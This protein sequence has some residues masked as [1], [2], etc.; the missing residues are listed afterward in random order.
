MANPSIGYVIDKIK[1]HTDYRG[2]FEK[3]FGKPAGMETVGMALAS[4]Q[5]TLN[6]AKSPFD[7]WYFKHD[8][9][10]LD[11]KAQQ[12]FQLFIGKAGCVACHSINTKY[13]LFT[14]QKLHNTGIG[15][16]QAMQPDSGSQKVQLAPNVFADVSKQLIKSVSEAKA[17]DLGRYEVSQNPAD[18]W[19]YKTPSLRNI[20]LTAPYMHNGSLGSLREVIEFYN[21]G[22]VANENL[23]GL[24]KSLNLS[25]QETDEL[26]AFLT[27]LTGDNVDEL[28]GDAIATPIGDSK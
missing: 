26:V 23:D 6:S 21:R 10:A 17:N 25:N 28:V 5:R 15:Y 8:K 2:L 14:D 12:G 4:Y 16:A 19:Q 7:R 27:A 1:H 11:S 24:I 22:G 13:A 9:N 3:A 20:A 18:R